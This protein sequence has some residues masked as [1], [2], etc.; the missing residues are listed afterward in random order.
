MK[1]ILFSS[2]DTTFD[3]NGIGRLDPMTCTVTE[4]RNGEYELQATLSI[5]GTTRLH[6]G[7]M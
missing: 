7:R 1:P 2:T 3:T 4:K 5:G 6:F